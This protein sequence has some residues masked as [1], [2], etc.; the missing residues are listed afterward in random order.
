[1]DGVLWR[2]AER[3]LADAYRYVILDACYEKVR[4]DGGI[5]LQAV[6]VAIGI[7]W[8]GRRQ[9][10]AVELANRESNSSWTA[11]VKGLKARG[12][13]GVALVV[14][15]GHVGLKRAVR[16]LLPEAVWQRWLDHAASGNSWP[17]SPSSE[18]QWLTRNCGWT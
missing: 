8:D 12:L 1:M 18:E 2:F 4:L 3:R 6:V 16:K 17:P 13:H 7:A 10:L 11:F 9:L 5:Q 15:D 14:S